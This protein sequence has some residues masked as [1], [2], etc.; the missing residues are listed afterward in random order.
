MLAVDP[1]FVRQMLS[2]VTA[3]SGRPWP[4]VIARQVHFSEWTLY[5]VFVDEVIRGLGTSFASDDSLCLGYWD[6]IPLN[7]EEAIRF[8]SRVG[9]THVAAMISAKSRTPLAIR[10]AAFA[11]RRAAE[12]AG[13]L[14]V[15]SG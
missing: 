14:V 13:R 6:E 15:S 5:G 3:T 1:A 11:R 7:L 10:R 2:R 12:T 9:P 8:L 4:T